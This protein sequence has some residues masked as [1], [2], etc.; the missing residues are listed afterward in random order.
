MKLTYFAAAVLSALSLTSPATAQ[1]VDHEV[2]KLSR[3]IPA[4]QSYDDLQRFMDIYRKSGVEVAAKFLEWRMEG[5]F[6]IEFSA[7]TMLMQDDY[8]VI[9]K[10]PPLYCI[11]PL[12][13]ANF[14]DPGNTPE[15]RTQKAL[16]WNEKKKDY[17]DKKRCFWTYSLEKNGFKIKDAVYERDSID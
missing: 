10:Q 8:K 16:E 1:L 14:G 15:E 4:C 7:C 3:R 17:E 2:W 11:D 13:Y 6:W 12:L 5:K 9:K